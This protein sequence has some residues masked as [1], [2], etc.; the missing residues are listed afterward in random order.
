MG[1]GLLPEAL[2]PALGLGQSALGAFA[3][4]P[5]I[6]LNFRQKHTGNQSVITWGLSV[7]G[8]T[9][10]IITTFLSV[11]DWIAL[12]GYLIAFVLNGTLVF[13][14]LFFW[15]NTQETIYGKKR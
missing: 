2:F 4:V 7:A 6:V 14:I 10:R 9:V 13:Q 3:C 12:A 15:Q 8:N 11:D 5:Q 1:M